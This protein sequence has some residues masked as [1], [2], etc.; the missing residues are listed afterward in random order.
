VTGGFRQRP[1]DQPLPVPNGNPGVHSMVIADIEARRALGISR[2]GVALQA[3]NGRDAL[4]D[5]YEE[6]LD[7]AAYLRQAI[8]ERDMAR[9]AEEA[10]QLCRRS[11]MSSGTALWGAD[12]TC[13]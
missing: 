13:T 12:R 5:A 8:E 11:W 7:C 4:R 10:A 3:G 1:G 6:I 9:R 2:Y